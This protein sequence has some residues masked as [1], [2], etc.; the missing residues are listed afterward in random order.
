VG[1]RQPT[2]LQAAVLAASK[3][4]RPCEVG[5]RGDASRSLVE[6]CVLPRVLIH[7]C[8]SRAP[9]AAI[10]RAP[11]RRADLGAS[12]LGEH[13]R[14]PGVGREWPLPEAA[15][16]NAVEVHALMA[17]TRRPK[18][19]D[20]AVCGGRVLML[21]ADFPPPTAQ[22]SARLPALVRYL[23]D[24]AWKPYVVTVHH[25]G[26][27]DW[28]Q[29]SLPPTIA[30]NVLRI[31]YRAPLLA[32]PLVKQW[33]VGMR[34]EHAASSQ[35]GRYREPLLKRLISTQAAKLH[36]WL[37]FP[38]SFISAKHG[39]LEVARRLIR[40]EGIQV[41][42]TSAPPQTMTALGHDLCL[43]SGLPWV[44]QLRDPF[45]DHYV[46]RGRSDSLLA[47][48]R[49]RRAERKWLRL[50]ST[51][52]VDTES[53]R[54][55]LLSKYHFLKEDQ[56]VVIR[57]GFEPSHFSQ[58]TASARDEGVFT[59]LHAGSLG[60]YRER[61]HSA[62]AFLRGFAAFLEAVPEATC[63]ARIDFAG[64][65]EPALVRMVKSMG[66]ARHTSFLGWLPHN[67]MLKRMQQASVLVLVKAEMVADDS[68]P[69]R[70]FQIPQKTYEYL[71]ARR[72]I[73]AIA[74][75]SECAD[76]VRAMGAGLIASP[77][78]PEE[79]TQAIISL[80]RSRDEPFPCQEEE[81]RQLEYP[82]LVG[83]VAQL[84][85]QAAHA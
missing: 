43:Q 20:T 26:E 13:S 44:C 75:P 78:R 27:P 73:L 23:G 37:Y 11:S 33:I 66:L 2:S 5:A 28:E 10:F 40:D 68:N 14:A 48:Y 65:E 62:L 47:A 74:P 59:M 32:N 1:S 19:K 18:Q 63:N 39:V 55:H 52:I 6:G 36:S 77:S 7:S 61:L 12:F 17:S 80:Y 21:A 50:P 60:V 67:E 70:S 79:I 72:P 84:L 71:G 82:V 24:Y 29:W 76:M 16:R 69:A 3:G 42:L 49:R 38:D 45:A 15:A 57:A 35:D 25:G 64:P 34:P 56:V 41:L 51:I 85:D 53:Y 22:A 4:A 58:T 83:R 31:Q 30:E 54:S 9:K 81:L 8:W 46:G